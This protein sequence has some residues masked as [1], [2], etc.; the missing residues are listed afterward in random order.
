MHLITIGVAS[1]EVT[2]RLYI[3]IES[4]TPAFKGVR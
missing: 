2:I 3:N 1:N 4:G